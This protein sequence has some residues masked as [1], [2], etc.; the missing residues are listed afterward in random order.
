MKRGT[1]SSCRTES[2]SDCSSATDGCPCDAELEGKAFACS[3]T[4][5]MQGT[6]RVCGSGTRECSDGVW[7]GC[8]ID[9]NLRLLPPALEEQTQGG[10]VACSDPCDQNCMTFNDDPVGEMGT[11]VVEGNNG[12]TLPGN[13]ASPIPPNCSGGTH[14][15]C[16][17]TICEPG[18]ALA[19]DCDAGLGMLMLTPMTLFSE[20]FSD[21]SQGWFMDSDW[22]IGSATG[23]FGHWSGN[24]DPGTDTT[25]TGDNGVL[26]VI[27][28][29]NAGTVAPRFM[30]AVS[31]VIDTS[32]STTLFLNFERWLNADSPIYQYSA[33]WAWNGTTW[34]EVW[35]GS[36]TDSSWQS[37]SEDITAFSNSQ[38]QIAFVYANLD[39][40][41]F[42]M[43]QWNIDDV[44]LIGDMP[45]TGP[46]GGSCVTTVCNIDP[47]C[48]GTEWTPVCVTLAA[49]NCPLTCRCNTVG[50]FL[51]CY[52][53]NFD[54][55]GD[56]YT[57]LDGDC[58]DCDVTINAGAFDVVD[59]LDNDCDGTADNEPV[60]CDAALSLTSTNILDHARA[61]D[62]CRDTTDGAMGS[63]RTWGVIASGSDLVQADEI[64][65]PDSLGH[66]IMAQFGNV[67]NIPFQSQ[68][69][70]VYSSGTARYPGQPGYVNP[71]GQSASYQHL[72]TSSFPPGFPVNAMGCPAPVGL[73][74]DSVG[75]KLRIRVPTNANS[76]SYKHRFYSSEYPEWVCTPFNDHTVS[77]MTGALYTGNLAFDLMNNAIS[78]NVGFFDVPGCP[79]C[80]DPHLTNT[81]FD[82]TCAGEICG[83]ATSWLQTTAPVSPGETIEVHFSIWD[84]GDHD[85]DSTVIVDDWIWSTDPTMVVG[86]IPIQPPDPP[87]MF[88]DGYYT[89]DYDV[90]GVCGTGTRPLWTN[91]T[92]T[93]DTPSDTYIDF[94]VRTADTAADLASAPGDAML[95]TDPPGPAAQLGMPAT[96]RLSPDTQIGGAYVD[97]TLRINGRDRDKEHLR[98]I[99]HLAPSTDMLMAPTLLGWNLQFECADNL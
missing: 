5:S 15:T 22:Q 46:P 4:V 37:V 32:A 96:A 74:N 88:T 20:D 30:A 48:C 60:D 14:G 7:S 84:Q 64:G 31:P 33:V 92:W 85:W 99:V 94:E 2:R 51:P 81:G 6:Q 18:V 26:G 34:F 29:G 28:G 52:N 27:I 65:T 45:V 38:L 73:A 3:Q 19:A 90:S 39:P 68:R 11:G 66:G 1:T 82:G 12:L 36:P 24:P 63:S 70:A 72:T 79:T 80:T 23:S 17:H 43:S 76:F 54:H 47:T 16:V 69:V 62:L 42:N 71:N 58:F 8:T 55:D 10:A 35:Q 49:A 91:W 56:G 44:E 77:I 89:R 40:L 86:T 95:F 97:E 13:L 21:N 61:I 93:A 25:P 78:V 83:G 87:I 67:S 59:T 9:G 75:P 98:I 50:E 53:D 41:V 57:G